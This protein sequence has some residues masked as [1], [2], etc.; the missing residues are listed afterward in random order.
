[1]PR[2]RLTPLLASAPRSRWSE[3]SLPLINI[4]FLMLIFFLIAG[5]IAPPLDQGLALVET[6]DLEG[7]EPPDALVLRADGS[8]TFR[9]QD[10]TA[11]RYLAQIAEE[12]MPIDEIRIVPDRAVPAVTLLE[13]GAALQEAG[14][15]RIFIVTERGLESTNTAP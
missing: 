9:Q 14:G 5:A 12:G 7:R 15:G 13:L 6:R 8:L 2:S 1:M 10:V 3:P 11:E 4:V